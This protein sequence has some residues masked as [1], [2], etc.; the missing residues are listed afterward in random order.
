MNWSKHKSSS[1]GDFIS[2]QPHLRYVHLNWKTIKIYRMPVINKRKPQT[3]LI[4]NPKSNHTYQRTNCPLSPHCTS[5]P[6]PVKCR[7]NSAAKALL[8]VSRCTTAALDR[9]CLLPQ[10]PLAGGQQAWM[11]CGSRML[12]G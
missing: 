11:P 8:R 12:L 9:A 7:F 2:I 10:A 6:W 1:F 4:N 5:F 3:N